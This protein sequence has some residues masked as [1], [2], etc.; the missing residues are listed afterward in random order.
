MAEKSKTSAPAKGLMKTWGRMAII[1]ASATQIE[2]LS[3]FGRKIAVT[4]TGKPST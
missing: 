4:P 2:S 1:D 3:A